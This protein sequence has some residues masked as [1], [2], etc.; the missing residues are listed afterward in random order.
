MSSVTENEINSEILPQLIADKQTVQESQKS[1]LQE[2]LLNFSASAQD[3]R[4]WYA[5]EDPLGEV[6]NEQFIRYLTKPGDT[7]IEDYFAV[8]NTKIETGKT[9]ESLALSLLA[10]VVDPDI[11]GNNPDGWH[12]K[13]LAENPAIKREAGYDTEQLAAFLLRQLPENLTAEQLSDL[14]MVLD[15]M[16]V[17]FRQFTN[18]GESLRPAVHTYPE[19]A[20][21][22][23]VSESKGQF[24]LT[25]LVKMAGHMSD[26]GHQFSGDNEQQTDMIRTMALQSGLFGA[27]VLMEH[28]MAYRRAYQTVESKRLFDI[29]AAAAIEIMVDLVESYFL[30]DLD[31]SVKAIKGSKR[32]DLHEALYLLDLNFLLRTNPEFAKWQAMPTLRRLDKPENGYPSLRRGYDVG[33]NNGDRSALI[34]LKANKHADEKRRQ[35]NGERHTDYHPRIW[36]LAEDGFD[37]GV[38]LVA[39]KMRAYREW[40]RNGFDQ[41]QAVVVDRKVLPTARETLEMVRELEKKSPTEYVLG[42]MVVTLSRSER[43]RMQRNLGEF[44]KRKRSK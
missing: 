20:L 35:A 42:G 22:Q 24:Y 14:G 9:H 17:S 16:H 28:G 43:R 31:P 3:A 41:E 26:H 30:K 10:N 40:A 13:Y 18:L 44:S 36:Q 25:A 4:D 27:S 23:K 1:E 19:Y 38:R 33:I 7:G 2:K 12:D 29:T 21:Q 39:S 15:S 6:Q 37:T 8:L 32:G 34:Q 11:I 5:T